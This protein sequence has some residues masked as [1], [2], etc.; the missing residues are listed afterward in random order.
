MPQTQTTHGGLI[1]HLLVHLLFSLSH[2]RN[3]GMI[4]GKKSVLSLKVLLK[5]G[6]GLCPFHWK[7]Q[8]SV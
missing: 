5:G 2:A 4:H 8:E 7:I 6:T 3:M 1:S